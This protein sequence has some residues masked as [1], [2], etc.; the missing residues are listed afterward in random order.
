M[1]VVHCGA[2]SQKIKWLGD[3]AIHR[4]D[5]FYAQETGLAKEI[6]FENGVVLN[7]EGMISDE[8]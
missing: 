2:G 6:R 5:Q 7:S 3:V 8:L 4:F 1:F